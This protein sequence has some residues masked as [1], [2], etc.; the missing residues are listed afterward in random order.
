MTPLQ[1]EEPERPAL[2]QANAAAPLPRF[3]VRENPDGMMVPLPSDIR[4][5]L[6]R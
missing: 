4:V 1:K 2:F 5:V 6:C 3:A